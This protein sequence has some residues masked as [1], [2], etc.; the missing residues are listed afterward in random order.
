LKKKNRITEGKKAWEDV[1]VILS[2]DQS[3]MNEEEQ[4]SKKVDQLYNTKK[5]KKHP[6][7]KK[8]KKSF[9]HV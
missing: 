5:G 8:H 1:S 2:A 7:A 4:E 9:E 3:F 6:A